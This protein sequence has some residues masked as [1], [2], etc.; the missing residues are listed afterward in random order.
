[1]TLLLVTAFAKTLF[2]VA[3]FGASLPAGI[4]LPSLCIGACV[5]RAVGIFMDHLHRLHPTAWIFG[6]CP[7][8]GACISPPVY[9]VIGAASAC[10]GVTRLTISLVVILFELTGAVDLVL[11]L[12]MS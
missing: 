9:A 3:T 8:E 4:F 7:T 1:M 2:T 5:G 12:M 6:N 11:Q 10:G